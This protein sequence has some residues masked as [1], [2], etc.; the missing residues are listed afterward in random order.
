METRK[1]RFKRIAEARTNRIIDIIQLLGNC[2]VK[3]NYEYT[4]AQ[5]DLIF[6]TIED[7]LKRARK[8]FEGNSSTSKSS[9][10]LK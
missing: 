8:K 5:V 3:T 1:D 2:S 9:F 6:N 10:R 7:E 4:S